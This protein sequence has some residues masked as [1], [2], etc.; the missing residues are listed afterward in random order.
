MIVGWFVLQEELF[1]LRGEIDVL[2]RAGIYG[3]DLRGA[4]EGALVFSVSVQP[5]E[6]Q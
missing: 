2:N 5:L 1:L 3:Q 4:D 6:G